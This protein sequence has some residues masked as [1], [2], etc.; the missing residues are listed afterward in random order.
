MKN[1]W[2]RD[3]ELG[4]TEDLQK[5]KLDECSN[6]ETCPIH[7]NTQYCAYYQKGREK[8]IRIGSEDT[9]DKAILLIERLNETIADSCFN[10]QRA[11]LAGN[12]DVAWTNQGPQCIIEKEIQKALR[13]F[14]ADVEKIFRDED[15]WTNCS[16]T[17]EGDDITNH[18]PVATLIEKL[19]AL[20]KER[21]L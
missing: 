1:I 10:I 12:S 18:I 13:Q 3:V 11:L 4:M 5:K 7:E 21:G 15:L 20:K 2:T 17:G 16:E 6:S 8:G 9:K 14:A 19:E